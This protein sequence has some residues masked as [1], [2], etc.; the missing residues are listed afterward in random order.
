M[1]MLTAKGSSVEVL[2]ACSSNRFSLCVYKTF[3]L[4][5]LTANWG[6]VSGHDC[7]AHTTRRGMLSLSVFLTLIHVMSILESLLWHVL[8]SSTGIQLHSALKVKQSEIRKRKNE[9]NCKT[10]VWSSLLLLH[11]TEKTP[12]STN[13]LNNAIITTLYSNWKILDLSI[14]NFKHLFPLL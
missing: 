9:Y 8:V 7:K 12:T 4:L 14:L 1:R 11:R 6:R 2:H 3:P 13:N 10:G 5:Y